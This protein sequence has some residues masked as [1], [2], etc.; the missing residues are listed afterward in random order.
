MKR[1]EMIAVIEGGGSILHERRLHTRIE[2]LP[3][4]ASLAQS[5]QEKAAAAGDLDAQIAALQ[6]QRAAL[7]SSGKTSTGG[8]SSENE[9]DGDS[10]NTIEELMKHT[11]AELVEKAKEAGA[12]IGEQDT[13]QQIAEAILAKATTEE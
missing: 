1:E 12:E 10:D 2:T 13:K 9:K 5:E 7:D 8:Q 6:A 4:K 11:R 3:T